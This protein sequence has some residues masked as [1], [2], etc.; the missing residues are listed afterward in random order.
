MHMQSHTNAY[1]ARFDIR[2]VNGE[3]SIT[4]RTR[5]LMIEAYEPVL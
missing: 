2:I 1:F 4:I 5:L 3:I